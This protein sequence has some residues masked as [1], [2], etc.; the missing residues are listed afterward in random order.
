LLKRYLTLVLFQSSSAG[1]RGGGRTLRLRY[2]RL[3]DRGAAVNETALP[4]TAKQRPESGELAMMSRPAGNSGFAAIAMQ[5]QR[6][7]RLVPLVMIARAF[8]GS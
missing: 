3:V 1:D 5:R 8:S 2:R 7:P 4:P 6:T